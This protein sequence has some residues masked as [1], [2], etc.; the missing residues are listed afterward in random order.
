MQRPHLLPRCPVFHILF[1]PPSTHWATP[2]SSWAQ[3]GGKAQPKSTTMAPQTGPLFSWPS[4][5]GL[6]YLPELGGLGTQFS[7]L[8]TCR[9][10][11]SSPGSPRW[12]LHPYKGILGFSDLPSCS[13]RIP[14]HGTKAPR[15]TSL[16]WPQIHSIWTKPNCSPDPWET[17]YCCFLYYP[18]ATAIPPLTLGS[19]A[20]TCSDLV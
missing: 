2:S 18:V 6:W 17:H 11:S 5:L 16:D 8:E 14:V 7:D 4:H 20:L 15:S 9:R 10:F 3:P 13:A 1:P 19:H 12:G